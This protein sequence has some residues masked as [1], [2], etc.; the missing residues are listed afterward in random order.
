MRGLLRATGYIIYFGAG[1]VLWFSYLM[2]LQD[3]LGFIGVLIA[4]IVSPGLVIFPIIVWVKT[5][6]F[7]LYYFA[8]LIGGFVI[9]SI[10]FALSS[11]GE[12]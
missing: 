5:G 4:I 1:V 7:P 2:F 12:D 8:L 11:I 6:V 9:G 10:F 3:W